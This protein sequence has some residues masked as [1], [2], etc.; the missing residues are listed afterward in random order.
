MSDVLKAHPGKLPAAH[1]KR[2]SW[3]LRA[4]GRLLPVALAKDISPEAR[5]VETLPPEQICAHV[6]RLI[7]ER[8]DPTMAKTMTGW[9]VRQ[10][11]Q[12]G[13]R[14]E[15]LGTANETLDMFQ[16][17]A[18]RLPT[19]QRDLGQYHSLAAVWDVVFPLAEAEQSKLSSRAR[20][21]ME[22]T[23]AYAESHILRQDEDGFT[24]AVPLTEFA[25]KWWGRGT[26]WCT[27]SK[28]YNRF[29][30]YHKVAPLFVFVIPELGAQGKFQFWATRDDFQFMDAADRPVSLEVQRA[31][32]WIFDPFM[33]FAVTQQGRS[34]R[35]IHETL[36]TIELWESAV[37]QNGVN[38]S[39]VPNEIRTERMC[40]IA[41][42]QD[43]SALWAVPK[44]LRTED[45]CKVAVGQYGR[46]LMHVPEALRTEEMCRIAVAENGWA[47]EFVPK[48]LRTDEVC[49]IAVAQQGGALMYVPKDLRTEELCR[50]A[51]VGNYSALSEVP[52][53]FLTDEF[54]KSLIRRNG[55]RL[56]VVPPQRRTGD[57][58]HLAVQN[59][60]DTLIYLAEALR[61]ADICKVAVGQKGHTLMHVPYRHRTYDLCE[62][63]LRHGASLEYVP[64]RLRT[65]ELCELAV[66]EN[67][68]N[69]KWV[70]K[71]L[72]S[73]AMCELAVRQSG[74]ALQY[75]PQALR[76]ST[77]CEIA[78]QQNGQ[79]LRHVPWTGRT[80]ELCRI[81]VA[82]N[83]CA[84]DYVPK[85][86]RAKVAAFRVADW[87]L[88]ELGQLMSAVG[89]IPRPNSLRRAMLAPMENASEPDTPLRGDQ[90]F[91]RA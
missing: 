36:V 70:P 69:L 7:L 3:A 10:Y 8:A 58:F 24:I 30:E 53:H 6:T 57:M 72:K 73:S 49:R 33:H 5:Q 78:L 40:L 91:V 42:A 43:G 89:L 25:A 74:W 35:K 48:L 76:T 59:D 14:L 1:E 22:K 15:D 63:A 51:A 64:N 88:D 13:L 68:G 79:T 77:L 85:A 9:L 55:W 44:K 18:S 71:A 12:G 41:V 38:L 31:N 81:A 32:R 52:G 26:R 60:G 17:Y 83:S 28:K 37:R 54:Y 21:D 67:G 80:M 66:S 87:K 65:S 50:I 39:I 4:Y 20:K 56:S 46:A 34:V 75:V 90:A 16:R 19:A 29:W 27:A 61:T 23:R 45:L 82:K 84:F 86:L 2:L 47:L 11:A 62:L